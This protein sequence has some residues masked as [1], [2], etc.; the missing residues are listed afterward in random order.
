MHDALKDAEQCIDLKPDF[1]K[2]YSRKGHVQYFMKEYE[3][4]LK[5]YHAGLEVD[6]DNEEMKEGI[7]NCMNQIN[8]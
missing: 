1:V 3:K 8:R 6:K 4:A 7:R 5:T 2:G